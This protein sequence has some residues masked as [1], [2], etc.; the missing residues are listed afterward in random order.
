MQH[1]YAPVVVAPGNS[2]VDARINGLGVEWIRVDVDRSGLNPIADLRLLAQYRRIL[3]RVRPIALLSFTAKPNIYGC[4]AARTTETA[5]IPNISGL[6]TAF[7]R[8]GPLRLLVAGLYR[9][10]LAKALTVFFQN[11]DDRK[12]FIEHRL[13]RADRA[14]L[15]P[16]SGVN[17]ERFASVAPSASATQFLFVGRLLGDKGVREFVAAARIVRLKHPDVRFRLLGPL[18]EGN[19]SAISR[20]ELDAWINEG[21]VEYLGEVDDVRPYLAQATAVV[22]P[23]YR[24]GL[25]RTLLEAAAMARPLIATDVPG[26]R[27]LI[28][29]GGNGFL[30]RSR[31]PSSLADAMVRLA[32]LPA[33]ERTAMGRASRK[34]VE[35][36]YSEQIVVQAYLDALGKLQASRS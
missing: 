2:G 15:L 18:D 22:L 34:M 27:E 9:L 26:C 19:R 20:A 10:A 33:G 12:L 24:E 14:R 36:R 31:D 32:H 4:L 6:G 7:M 17:L 29:D 13:V 21:M 35:E 5:A 30:C 23:S 28:D 1:G 3:N 25:P 11:P 8:T 16:G